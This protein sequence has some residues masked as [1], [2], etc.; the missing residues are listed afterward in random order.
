MTWY[1]IHTHNRIVRAGIASHASRNHYTH[2]L[3]MYGI[4]PA[5]VI[6]IEERND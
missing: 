4:A 6:A 1:T 5:D 2:F 3:E